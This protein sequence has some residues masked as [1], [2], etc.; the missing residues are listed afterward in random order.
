MVMKK[1][2]EKLHVPH[3]IVPSGEE[4]LQLWQNHQS[5]ISLIFMDIEVDGALN[6]IQVAALIRKMESESDSDPESP[7]QE[8]SL[9]SSLK[10]RVY[11]AVMTGRTFEEDKRQAFDAGCD[12]FLLKPVNPNKIKE[13]VLQYSA[14]GVQAL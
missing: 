5:T 7:S 13:L 8:I 1:Q 2:L 4:A 9:S 14:N 3:W 10:R 12:E 6:G 11:I